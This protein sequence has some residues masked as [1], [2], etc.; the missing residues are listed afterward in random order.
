M[1]VPKLFRWLSDRYP[2]CVEPVLNAT[3]KPN[4]KGTSRIEGTP[5]STALPAVREVYDNLYLDLNGI[6]HNCSHPSNNAT[7]NHLTTDQIAANIFRYVSKIVA[8]VRPR[9]LLYIAV[10]GVAPRAKMNQQR[11]RRF[12]AAADADKSRE[13]LARA[14]LAVSANIFD[15]NCISPGTA[16]ME[17]L[18][19]LLKHFIARKQSEDSIWRHVTVLYSG[20][21][22]PGEGEHKIMDFIRSQQKLTQIDEEDKIELS[23]CFYGLDADLLLLGL[24]THEHYVSVLREETLSREALIAHRRPLVPERFQLVH[25]SV[26]RDYLA[27][28]FRPHFCS[29]KFDVERLINDLLL[30]MSLVGDDFLPGI[31]AMGIAEHGLEHI[32][33]IYCRTLPALDGYITDGTTV[34]QPRLLSLLRTFNETMVVDNEFEYD[35]LNDQTFSTEAI[36]L[37][38]SMENLNINN[39]ITPTATETEI[40]PKT[41]PPEI[42]KMAENIKGTTTTIT[43]L[44]T[45]P[46]TM[47]DPKTKEQ[48]QQQL[49][50]SRKVK[51][52][53]IRNSYYA[54]KFGKENSLDANPAFIGELCRHYLDGICW[55]L[56]YY[57]GGCPS[58]SWFFPY[59]YAPYIQELAATAECWAPPAFDLG[60]PVLP[61]QQLLCVLPAASAGLVPAAYR[62]LLT[63]PDSPIA[64]FYPRTF[65]TDLNGKRNDWESVVLIPFIDASAVFAAMAAAEVTSPLSPSEAERNRNKIELLYEFAEPSLSSPPPPQII[66]SPLTTLLPKRFTLTSKITPIKDRDT[67]LAYIHAKLSEPSDFSGSS[68]SLCDETNGC[69]ATALEGTNKGFPDLNGPMCGHYGVE[70]SCRGVRININPS[71]NR[72]AILHFADPLLDPETGIPIQPPARDLLGKRILF[73]WP[74]Y[75]EGIVGEPLFEPEGTAPE[76]LVRWADEVDCVKSGLV[77]SCGIELDPVAT[78]LPVTPLDSVVLDPTTGIIVDRIY[79]KDADPVA[80]PYSLFSPEFVLPP[81]PQKDDR[82]VSAD[83]D[84]YKFYFTRG[85]ALMCKVVDSESDSDEKAKTW[86]LKVVKEIS[87]AHPFVKIPGFYTDEKPA[88]GSVWMGLRDM[89]RVL[90]VSEKTLYRLTGY[91]RCDKTVVSFMLHSKLS[92]TV[93]S[94]W[95]RTNPKYG[96]FEFAHSILDFLNY[97]RQVFPRLFDLVCTENNVSASKIAPGNPKAAIETLKNFTAWYESLPFVKGD[98]P[99]VPFSTVTLSD[100]T[101]SSIQR[102]NAMAPPKQQQEHPQTFSV[103]RNDPNLVHSYPILAVKVA[104]FNK[105]SE[106]LAGFKLGARVINICNDG[107]VP[108]GAAGT[109][110][111]VKNNV[112]IAKTNAAGRGSA[113][114]FGNTTYDVLFDEP[115]C[116]GTTLG[117]KCKDF[118]G[119]SRDSNQLVPLPF[120]RVSTARTGGFPMPGEV[121]QPSAPAHK[122][123]AKQTHQ[124]ETQP[125]K[126]EQTQQKE[127]QEEHKITIVRKQEPRPQEKQVTTLRIIRKTQ[128]PTVQESTQPPAPVPAPVPAPTATGRQKHISELCRQQ[129]EQHQQQLQQLQKLQAQCRENK[130][131]SNGYKNL[132]PQRPGECELTWQQKRFLKK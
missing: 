3:C 66:T 125:P 5:S 121:P 104:D 93:V 91:T 78:L 26:L 117:S 81:A 85:K 79:D 47:G 126:Q 70:F 64:E 10:D 9:R 127:P 54:A 65:K 106:Y 100:T 105:K 90:K 62:P 25:L 61:F 77:E 84:D 74:Y 73:G 98:F 116:S 122:E 123:R 59:H 48:Q 102:E 132:E 128:A 20:H 6:I 92:W 19:G 53:A 110:I 17:E 94:G 23:H 39:E 50:V 43:T 22:V 29:F 86:N 31:P 51:N 40:Y 28:E 27:L 30:L 16:F 120:N 89:A 129:Q 24:A 41:V 12:R 55:V 21:D 45:T 111:R 42:L 67:V 60:T 108:I 57:L 72:S 95:C 46:P 37:A 52:R 103:Q 113:P 7:D 119:A 88:D 75:W 58:W 80:V 96:Y 131:C 130:T 49:Q 63:A 82:Y 83:P 36:S 15:S 112:D 124:K 8:L 71:R 38:N 99:H 97:Y 101:I 33:C 2:L 13:A 35:S 109:I 114:V 34:S 118:C 44:T 107:I 69:G 76:E 115:F 11:S 32:F 14:G 56:H 4:P 68:G 87:T 18:N 1:G